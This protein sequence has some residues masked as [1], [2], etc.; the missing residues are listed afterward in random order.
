MHTPLC[1]YIF[2]PKVLISIILQTY[3]NSRCQCFSQISPHMKEYFCIKTFMLTFQLK[4][5]LQFW[6]AFTYAWIFNRA[7]ANSFYL[8]MDSAIW[9][10]LVSQMLVCL[11]SMFQLQFMPNWVSSKL[12]YFWCKQP[13]I[14]AD[15]VETT[16]GYPKLRRI[17][18]I[19]CLFYFRFLK[20]FLVI[21][22]N[23]CRFLELTFIFGAD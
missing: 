4:S 16:F 11:H 8:K 20:S 21:S 3:W 1:E 12:D 22:E 23:E 17:L 19:S 14:H 6:I 10:S 13:H 2:K 15:I 5:P 18:V 9:G 7:L